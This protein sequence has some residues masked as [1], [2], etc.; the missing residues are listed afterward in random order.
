MAAGPGAFRRSMCSAAACHIR[1]QRCLDFSN[2]HGGGGRMSTTAFLGM[3]H[4]G[5]N[6]AAAWSSFAQPT[7]GFDLDPVVV[8]RLQAGQ[9]PAQ[10]PGLGEVIAKSGDCLAFSSDFSQLAGCQLA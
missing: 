9:L 6:Y 5:I 10:E 2:P 4:L 3:S 8:S 1:R 7:I